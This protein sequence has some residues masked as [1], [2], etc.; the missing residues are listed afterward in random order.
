MVAKL[1]YHTVLIYFLSATVYS[2][3][4]FTCKQDS[5][6]NI[7]KILKGKECFYTWISDASASKF[8]CCL[9]FF[10]HI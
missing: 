8:L 10:K 2:D 3:Q 4:I 5:F 6:G 1:F 7:T 9:T